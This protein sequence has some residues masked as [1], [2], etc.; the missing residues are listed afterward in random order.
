MNRR[1]FRPTALAPLEERI[2]LSHAGVAAHVS[3]HAMNVNAT[4]HGTMTTTSPPKGMVGGS[5][6]ATLSGNSTIPK[7]GAV[8]LTGKLSDNASLAPP[9]SNTKGSI[10]LTLNSRKATGS[11]TVSVNGPPTN[12][13][14]KAGTEQLSFT[15]TSAS[16][17]FASFLGDKG[18][19]TLSFHL[20][21]KPHSNVSTGPFTLATSINVG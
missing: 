16:G 17:A 3:A 7:L 19:A 11:M 10:T 13:A 15:V 6:N 18:T 4:A 8:H 9:Y 1:S 5:Q 2:A 12:L 21:A 20:K 14:A